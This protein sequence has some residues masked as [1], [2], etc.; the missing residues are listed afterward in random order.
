MKKAKIKISSGGFGG[1]FSRPEDY[2]YTLS[3]FLKDAPSIQLTPQLV[4]M[5]VSGLSDIQS[6]KNL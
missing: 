6:Q 5:F 2:L 3:T 4:A 1:S